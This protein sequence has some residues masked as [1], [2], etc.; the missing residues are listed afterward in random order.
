MDDKE[1]PLREDR[2]LLGRLL[3]DVI[4]EQA[5]TDIFE[6]VEGIRQAAVAFRKENA[7]EAQLDALL[8]ALDLDQT[9]DVVRAFSFFSHLLNIAEDEQ[10]HRRRQVHAAA[11]SPRRPGSLSYALDQVKSMGFEKLSA[12]FARAQVM[13]VLTAHP[14]EVQRQSILDCEREIAHLIAQPQSHERDEAIH[15][16]V[17]RLWLTSMLRLHKLQVSDEVTNGIGFFRLTFLRELPR[18]YAEFEHALKE[19]FELKELPWL[20]PFLT[21]GSWI[22]GDRDGNPN[23]D[24]S[25]LRAAQVLH[26]R[27]V[28]EHYLAE[29][30][31]LGRELGLSARLAHVPPEVDALAERSGDP[32]PHRADEPYRR[33]L[34]GIYA[35]LAATAEALRLRHARRLAVGDAA[36][37]ET[38]AAFGS[39]LDAID[40]SLREGGNAALAAG[41][42]ARLR[43]A[44]ATFGFHLAPVDLR[45]NSEVHE[46][47]VAELLHAAGLCEDYRALDEEGRCA[48]LR[49]ELASPRALRTRFG[50][51]SETTQGELAILEAAAEVLRTRG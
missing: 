21:V 51:Y 48:L 7:G 24:G 25:V 20:A 12:R 5:G 49:A 10:Q 1:N 22:G 17:L 29:V 11:G 31:A 28:F 33:A 23:V 18:L 8:N 50:A 9:M 41:R 38:A 16:E 43:K 42:L 19:R 14:T 2:R 40:A 34:T 26:A 47:V 4:R 32:S 30:N 46:E 27:V 37:Y 36:P 15:A 35:R 45:Q 6:R 44:A 13:P 3:G 39:A